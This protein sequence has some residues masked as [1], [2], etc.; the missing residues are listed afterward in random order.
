MSGGITFRYIRSDLTKG[1]S[2]GAGQPTKAGNAYAV[3][4]STYYRTPMRF[5]TQEGE[6]AWGVNISNI[7]SKISYVEGEL[8]DFIPAN[9]RIGTS[10]TAALDAY[11]KI[12]LG[13][14]ANKLLV[15]SPPQYD[16][17]NGELVIIKGMNPDVSTAQGIFQSFYDAPYGASEEFK[18]ISFSVGVEYWYQNQFALRAGYF[19]ESEMKGNRKY[20]TVGLGLKLTVA[21]LDFSYLIPSGGMNNPL[22]NTMRISASFDIGKPKK[23]TATK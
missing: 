15:P 13:F 7:G 11:N 6:W 2:V 5:G 19:N 21:T 18:E 14:D 9:L 8:A 1:S 20:A 17:I 10:V 16:T 23:A 3:D 12:T 4:I 22:A